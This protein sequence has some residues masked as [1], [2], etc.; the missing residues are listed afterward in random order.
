MPYMRGKNR[1]T[2]GGNKTTAGVL[3]AGRQVALR[4]RDQGVAPAIV[5]AAGKNAAFAYAEFFGAEI[6]NPHTHRAY[7]HAVHAF[8]QWCEEQGYALKHIS[9]P[10]LGD[11]MRHLPGS[12]PTQKLHLAAIRH[13]FDRLVVRHAVVLNP[14]ASV[15]G[16]RYSA[17]EGKTPALSVEQARQVLSSINTNTVV[18]LR[19]R[20]IIATLIYTAARAGAVAKLRLKDYY[21]DGHQY[22]LHFDEK[23]GKAREIP[24]RYD[25][26]T[27]LEDYLQTAG[28]AKDK[29]D[30]PLFRTTVRKT[31]ILTRYA[32]T[33]NDIFRLIKRRLKQAGLP[34]KK[35]SSHSFRATTITDLL[36]QGVPLEDV[37]YL[38]GHADPRTTR[39]YDRRKKQATRNIVERISV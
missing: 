13:F 36:E 33:S 26:Q 15:R 18:G 37:Q 16:P 3:G 8:L 12:K 21:P 25:L 38:A 39:L 23:G 28:L 17:T 27:Y 35:L 20:A 14:A 19:D 10:L 6:E 24:V 9:P 11:Y 32:M 31:K 22:W 2:K 4:D 34:A 7:R 1:A 30:S 29:D 5:T